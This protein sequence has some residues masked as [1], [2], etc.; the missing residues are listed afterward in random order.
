MT[1]YERTSII[2]MRAEQLAHGA[3]STLSVEQL[4]GL[5]NVIDIAKKEFDI[6]V[7]PMAIIRTMPNGDK[8]YL[9]P[10]H[11]EVLN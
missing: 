6:H 1:I 7:I 11:M 8:K 9:D 2:G 4:I 5:S 10:D 3:E